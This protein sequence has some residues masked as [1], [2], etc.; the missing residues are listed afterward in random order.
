MKR[1]FFSSSLIWQSLI[2]NSFVKPTIERQRIVEWRVRN[3]RRSKKFLR[4]PIFVF[5]ENSMKLAYIQLWPYPFH[6]KTLI[7]LFLTISDFTQRLNQI[8][9]RWEKS[10]WARKIAWKLSKID[11]TITI[12][13]QKWMIS[14]WLFRSC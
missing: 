13:S 12:V 6:C 10:F 5:T 3:Q 1:I 9:K 4:W 8:R 11:G 7:L 14:R 2:Q